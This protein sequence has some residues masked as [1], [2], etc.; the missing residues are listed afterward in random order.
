[1]DEFELEM[2]ILL[3]IILMSFCTWN[4][5]MKYKSLYNMKPDFDDEDVFP[6]ITLWQNVDF[7]SACTLSQ[8]GNEI[9]IAGD[10]GIRTH[11]PLCVWKY[12]AL[13]F[14]NRTFSKAFRLSVMP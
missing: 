13:F 1:M 14:S 5:L 4:E 7:T 12:D 9:G 11:D 3:N 6:S 10:W 2:M 8:K